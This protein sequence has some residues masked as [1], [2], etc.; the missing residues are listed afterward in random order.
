MD[1][2]LSVRLKGAFSKG[3]L[4]V[5]RDQVGLARRGRVN[6]DW[7][8]ELGRLELRAKEEGRVKLSLWR[9]AD[10]DWLVSLVYARDPLPADE[11]EALRRRILDAA[12]HAGLTVTAQV[13]S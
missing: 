8:A 9:Y 12:A 3:G 4:S 2:Q 5:F 6:D 13:P 11:V 1:S 7:D 10:D